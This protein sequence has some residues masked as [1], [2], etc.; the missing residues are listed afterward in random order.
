MSQ[1]LFAV[2]DLGSF[3]LIGIGLGFVVLW[4]IDRS[5]VHALLFAAAILF[6][7]ASNWVLSLSG[8]IALSSSIHG[9]LLPIGFV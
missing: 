9:I 5:R 8:D 2:I 6:W 3:T 4:L 7:F 1:G